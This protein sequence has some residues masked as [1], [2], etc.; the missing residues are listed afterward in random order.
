MH[1]PRPLSLGNRHQTDSVRNQAWVGLVP[2]SLI[3]CNLLHPLRQSAGAVS[4]IRGN[5]DLR[6]AGEQRNWELAAI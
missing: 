5:S 2:S 6:F 1:R 3:A 4:E